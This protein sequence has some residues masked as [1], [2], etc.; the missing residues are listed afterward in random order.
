MKQEINAQYLVCWCVCLRTS[1]KGT[2]GIYHADSGN[3]TVPLICS[4]KRQASAIARELSQREDNK[5]RRWLFR[6]GRF[7]YSGEVEVRNG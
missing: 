6:A 1:K 5:H 2:W 7:F 3:S 4:S